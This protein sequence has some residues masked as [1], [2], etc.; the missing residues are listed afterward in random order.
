MEATA[1]LVTSQL[2]PN[3]RVAHSDV[4][5]PYC[6]RSYG[7]QVTR[8]NFERHF[9]SLAAARAASSGSYSIFFEYAPGC[10]HY[11]EGA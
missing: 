6:L 10:G 4:R 8:R 9:A 2:L 5:R 11:L 3:G 1:A 7:S